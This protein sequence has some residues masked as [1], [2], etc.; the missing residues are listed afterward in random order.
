[1]VRSNDGDDLV[2]QLLDS[3]GSVSDSLMVENYYR[4]DS[5][6]IERVEL[7][8]GT[9]WSADDFAQLWI[10]GGSGN[11]YLHS[12]DGYNDVFDSD[13]GGNDLLYGYGGDNTYWLGYGT[14]HDR[15]NE[16]FSNDGNANDVIKLKEGIGTEDVQM[17]RSRDGNSLVVQLL[18]SNGSVSDSLTVENYYTD[19]SAKI[20]RV[21]FVDGTVWSANDFAQ[22]L[23]RGTSSNENLYG[24]DNY[25]DIFDSDAGGNDRLFGKSGDD[26]YWLGYGTGHD[27]IREY[28]F[29]NGDANDVIKL[30]E[31]I[32][33]EDVQLVRSND[34][35]DL[36]VQLLASDGSV[37]DSLTVES[38]YTDDSAKI[39]Q[40][41][42]ADGT[43]WSANDFAQASIRGTSS[44]ENLYGLDNY[45]DIFDSDAGG[46]DQLYGYGGDDT[47][48]LGYGTGHDT[49]REY[50]GDSVDAN[51]VIKLKEGI[52]TNDVQLSRSN[53]GDDLIVQLLDSNGSVSD[54]LTVENYY[55]DDSA[56]IE[57]VEFADGTVWSANDFAQA[58]IRGTS[59]D[60]NLYGLDNYDD[61][62]DADAG[63]D[64]QLYGYG[65]D[66]TYWLGYGTG[67]DTIREHYNNSGDANDVIKLK[68]GIG[69]ED[70]RLSRSN[71]GDDL[72]VQL[73]ASDGSVSDSL[74]VESYY[75]DDSAK[76]ER[77]EFADGTVW[78]A[79]DFA[80]A[81]I[82]GTSADENL[83]GLDNYNDIFDSDAGGDDRLFG[84]GG[85]DTYWLGY[86][87]GHDTIREYDFNN[88]DAND[89]IKLK[90][91]IGTEDVQMV[92]SNNGYSLVV[93]L[94]DSNGSVSDSLTVENYY[95]DDSAKIEQM[96]FADGTVWSANDFAQALIRGTSG[97]ENLY[98]DNDVANV[99]DSD[100]GGNDRLYG[101]SGDDT[102]WLGYGTGYD[103]IREHY[104]NSG[105]ANDVIKLKEGIGT[106]DVR[107]SR[108]NDG[109]DLI[110]QLLASDGSVSDS[111]TVESYYT[112]DSAKI[113]QVE[114]ADGTVWSANDFAQ[115]SIRGTSSDEN[116][117]GLDNY[118]DIFDSAA[119]GN[120]NLFGYSG[121]DTYW[122][123]YGTGHDTIREYDNNS[124][125]TNDV[126]KL[127]KDI[128]TE[129]VQMVRSNNG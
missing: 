45:N 126:I 116:L 125:D 86:E 22:A 82:R 29:N 69:T 88:G 110:V 51:D 1:M 27:T 102:Y 31:G 30:K 9:V 120:D 21:E 108:S 34:G 89:V 87:T 46:D 115:A 55:T 63:G 79:N 5:A 78:S 50:L 11:D 109:D 47:Y 73:L 105:D 128:G 83:Y 4:D 18:D 107:L 123:I 112:D 25:N 95:V 33:T 103:T 3:N 67:Y 113:E 106:E 39:E 129:D 127:K 32:G 121:D 26:T 119:G 41:E 56:K 36:I 71:D 100:A 68:E 80:Q 84:Y 92:R 35:D 6:R 124:G 101:Y 62:F 23:I 114:F 58:R 72:I 14:D 8:D 97:D 57:R 17:V 43:V 94:L 90:E 75:T 70:V 99:F 74:T 54:S 37:S 98:G 20:E 24:L 85:D 61:V 42:F 91:G 7:V 28:D 2:V 59:A 10:R 64:D 76:I 118:N 117:Y 53:D 12:S 111:L 16:Y 49:I 40:V 19:D 15:I 104:N 48:W 77:V 93:Q 13:A 60:E 96:E 66:D 122:L 81:P 44:D 65:G 52:E 38:Y